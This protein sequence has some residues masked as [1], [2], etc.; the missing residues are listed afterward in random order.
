LAKLSADGV[1]V[2]CQAQMMTTRSYAA[3]R[4]R[5]SAPARRRTAVRRRAL[6]LVVAMVAVGVLVIVSWPTVHHDIQRIVLPLTH[7]DIIRQQAQEKQLDPGLIAAVIDA[8]SKFNDQDTSSAGA[9]GLMQLEPDTARFIARR[10]GATNFHIADLST[11]QVN[12]AYGAWYLHY[13]LQRYGG[14]EALALAAYNGGEANVDRWLVTAS[15]SGRDFTVAQIPFPET[16]AYVGK[17]LGLR[18]SYRA[19][20]A[21]ELGI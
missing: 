17:V 4:P 5:S 20:Y 1:V 11:P 10:S 14:N 3:Q 21:S 12:I 6:G 15:Q 16:R 13:L 7:A 2:T 8:E 19:A 18:A 9:L